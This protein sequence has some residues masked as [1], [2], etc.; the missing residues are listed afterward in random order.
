[1]KF[2]SIEQEQRYKKLAFRLQIHERDHERQALFYIIAGKSDLT[3]AVNGI[4]D[5]DA[6]GINPKILKDAGLSHSEQAL[7]MLGFN[8]FNGFSEVWP[9]SKIMSVLDKEG[10]EIALNAVRIRF[11]MD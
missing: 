4:Y 2:I 1:M 9:I 5:F 8:L 3:Q 6:D 10:K 11:S 7:I